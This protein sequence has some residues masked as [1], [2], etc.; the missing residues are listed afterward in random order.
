MSHMSLFD[1]CSLGA[2]ML[3]FIIMGILLFLAIREA[4]R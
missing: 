1:A 3:P 2:V 4:T